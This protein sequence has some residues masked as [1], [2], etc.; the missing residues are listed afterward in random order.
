MKSCFF[1]EK[2]KEE[3]AVPFQLS[4]WNADVIYGTFR[5]SFL[6]KVNIYARGTKSIAIVV[7][8]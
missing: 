2:F 5:R 1:N 8:E 7:G 4:R 6:R 3:V